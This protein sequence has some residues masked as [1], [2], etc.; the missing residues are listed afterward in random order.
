MTSGGQRSNDVSGCELRLGLTDFA[1]FFEHD[2][3]NL[4]ALFSLELFQSNSGAQSGRSSSDDAN[5]DIIFRP[6]DLFLGG[7]FRD[8]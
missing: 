4:S 7:F 8:R 1:S 2:D 6:L 3:P 5:I